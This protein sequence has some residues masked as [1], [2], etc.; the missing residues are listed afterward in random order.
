[1]SERLKKEIEKIDIPINL[2]DIVQKGVQRAKLEN[3]KPNPQPVVS[4]HQFK[5]Y[6]ISLIAVAVLA[7]LLFPAF[8]SLDNEKETINGSIVQEQLNDGETQL[9]E[10]M[11]Q[12]ISDYIVWRYQQ[13]E[14]QQT[15]VQFEVHKVYG[16]LQEGDATTVYMWSYYNSFNLAS[17]NEEV[18]GASLPVTVVLQNVAG[19]YKVIQ[20]EEAQDG[21]LYVESI[22]KMFPEK[23]VEEALEQ[24]GNIGE[25][26]EEMQQKVTSWLNEQKDESNQN[27]PA[28]E[29]ES[30]MFDLT[31]EEAKAYSEFQQDFNTEHL[32]GLSPIN[33]AKLYIFAGFEKKYNVQ[34]ALY[35]DREEYIMWSEEE[36]LKIPES[37]RGNFEIYK[38]IDEG[39]FIET[40]DHTGYI[41]FYINEELMGFQMIKN[42][43][44]I[45]QV[46]FMPIQ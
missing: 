15:D 10:E 33:I 42:A 46:S 37:D 24:P 11:H 30:T 45:W 26:Q 23:Y 25:L 2:D 3:Q 19:E 9:T 6:L 34:Y 4:K 27:S 41:E 22:K 1:M 38:N 18:T 7:L 36:D 29:S 40:S 13:S 14:A 8:Q 17:R 35:T 20:Y 44:G 43:D 31:G 12:R 39:T 28:T 21:S 16:T 32:S 5:P